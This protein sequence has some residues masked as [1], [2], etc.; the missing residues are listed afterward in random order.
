[1]KLNVK[2]VSV[3]AVVII[4][5]GLIISKMDL[6]KAEE[7]K[8]SAPSNKTSKGIYIRAMEVAKESIEEVL[9]SKGSIIPNEEVVITSES[10]GKVTSITFKE[11]DYVS[12]GQLLVT[13][14]DRELN[15]QLD[16]AKF[17]K[18]FLEKKAE[19]EKQ[20]NERGGVSD[21]QY[22]STIRDLQTTI[23][24]IELI[25]T[26]IEKKKIKAP[27]AGRIGLR[28][29]SEGK[30]IT[31]DDVIAE[32]V[33]ASS[34]KIDFTL[35]E[36]YMARIKSGTEIQFKIDGLA[37]TF[38][39]KV[40]AVEPKIDVNTRTI[41]LRALSSNA[42]GKILPGAFANVSIIL[43][44]IEDALCVPTEAIIPEMNTKKIFLIKEGK[45]VSANVETGLRLPDKIQITDGLTEGDSV[46]ISGILK[47]RNGTQ[48]NI[49]D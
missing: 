21:E 19:R 3:S 1:M 25:E 14:D 11:G 30:Y 10:S 13:L 35:P 12:K 17:E 2:T 4:I 34:I 28:Y 23:A 44:R 38:N 41:S 43:N 22:E 42:N 32:L 9:Q 31:T 46:I 39:G 27:F 33:D 45:A 15:A 40:Y 16:K 29:I 37:E 8:I 6:L 47:V 48:L 49:L 20:L 18:E 24:D 36:K 7:Q 5:F 26:Q